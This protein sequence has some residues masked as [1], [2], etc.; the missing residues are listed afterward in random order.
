MD[1]KLYQNIK[2][3][4]SNIEELREKFSDSPDVSNVYEP[5]LKTLKE[6]L[7]NE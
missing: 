4:I 5:I 3:A 7:V 2:Q 6:K 1:N